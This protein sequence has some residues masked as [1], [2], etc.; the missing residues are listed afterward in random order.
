MWHQLNIHGL[1]ETACSISSNAARMLIL[2]YRGLA[3]E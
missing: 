3:S 1:V 2:A